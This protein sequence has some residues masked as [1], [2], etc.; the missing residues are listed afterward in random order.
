MG[1][2][3]KNACHT[4]RR[5]RLKCD[6]SKPQ[7]QRCSDDRVDCQGYGNL[8][9]WVDGVASRG[10]MMGKT[11]QVASTPPAG[12][13]TTID[14]TPK[15]KQGSALSKYLPAHKPPPSEALEPQA[16]THYYTP[17]DPWFQ[18]FDHPTRHY[19]SHF[20]IHVGN[21]LI[22]HNVPSHH[23]NPLRLLLGHADWKSSL[24]HVII[25]MSAQHLHNL[26]LRAPDAQPYLVDGLRSKGKALQLLSHELGHVTPANYTTVLAS[27]ML[28]SELA[29]LESADDTW[30]I[31]V[32]AAASL[33][34]RIS[35]SSSVDPKALGE[36]QDSFCSWI[37]SRLILQDMF[38]SSLSSTTASW[39]VQELSGPQQTLDSALH[40]AELDHYSSCPAQ[41]SRLIISAPSFYRT[42]NHL[43]CSDD[44]TQCIFVSIHQFDPAEWALTL[45]PLTPTDDFTERYHIGS[46]YRAAASIYVSQL[47]PSGYN[48][49]HLPTEPHTLVDE[50][51]QQIAQIPRTNPLF[52]STIWPIF[53]AGAQT[54]DPQHRSQVLHHLG[55]L[56]I[57][58]PWQST[59][60]AEQGL[61]DFWTRI[62]QHNA[63]TGSSNEAR[64]GR[65]WLDEFRTM[66]VSIYPA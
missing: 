26:L 60:A 25:A 10:K 44:P 40:I 58:I 15:R 12:A 21:D 41:I 3:W 14:R 4:C 37:I 22:V 28:L 46:A 49:A 16:T 64:R 50:I 42:S 13:Q 30:R 32:G 17:L 47:V 66:G 23:P 33:V 51:L 35:A 54:V 57:A 55:N 19:L 43:S 1:R 45:Q 29:I 18:Q 7:C 20:L 53:I 56:S 63:S 27:S 31:H 34:Q 2:S 38:G 24:F 9:L 62:D 8:I 5:R 59:Y 11:F 52:K 65:R 36:E 6:E 39:N 48:C 61:Q